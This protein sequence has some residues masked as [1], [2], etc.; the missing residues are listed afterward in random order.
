MQAESLRKHQG[1]TELVQTGLVYYRVHSVVDPN[2]SHLI[3]CPTFP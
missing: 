1:Q 3:P 2:A